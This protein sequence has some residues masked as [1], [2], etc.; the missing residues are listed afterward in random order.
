MPK[1]IIKAYN[2]SHQYLLFIDVEFNNRQLI[3][4]AGLLFKWIDDETY[5]LAKCFNQ[6]VTAKVGYPFMEYTGIKNDFLIEN[7]I[8]L[9]DLIIGIQED[10]LSDV[11]LE[12][13][14]VISHGLKNDRLVLQENGINLS[15]VNDK[16]I[17]GYCTFNNGRRI[18]HRDNNLK[19]TNIAEEAGYYMQ[20][21]HNAYEDV[22]AE[23]S[24]FTFLRKLEEQSKGDDI[25]VLDE[26]Q[27]DGDK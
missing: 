22:W 20:N 7:G 10:L 19:L 23:V 17:A 16:P 2:E 6:Y 14:L 18:L 8:P 9:K 11:D 15:T 1:M 4:F 13:L 26:P 21:A 25:D 12:D 3:Q 24:V 5:Q 27:Q